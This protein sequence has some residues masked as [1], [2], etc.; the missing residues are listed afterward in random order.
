MK[1]RQL[2]ILNAIK[3]EGTITGAANRLFISQP[4]LSLAVKELET[5]LGVTLFIRNNQ[6]IEFT[7]FGDEAY[8]YSK[9]ILQYIDEIR[10]IPPDI[11]S[12]QAKILILSS[13]Y[14]HGFT[15][16]TDTISALEQEATGIC[17]Y[18]FA[19]DAEKI[20]WRLL[21]SN[22]LNEDVDLAVVKIY[23]FDFKNKMEQIKNENLVFEK[24]F[25]E[26]LVIVGRKDHPLAKKKNSISSLQNYQYISE[27]LKNNLNFYIELKYGEEFCLSSM[28]HFE[29]KYGII[30][31]IHNT[32]AF[33]VFSLE[34][35]ENAYKVYGIELEVIE[36]DDFDLRRIV[37]CLR[38]NRELNWAESQ[39]T[40]K[41]IELKKK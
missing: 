1:L 6:G 30:K 12:S 28:T 9:Q 20:A 13:N 39:F 22:L 41:L 38:K 5:E 34:E 15:L 2:E 31:Y 26:S 29:S 25:V 18:Q 24:L 32:D 3:E 19:N 36:I 11:D 33:S 40:E 27:D 4:S 35:V 8:I 16:L 7:S 14:Y 17:K 37:G 21:I 10:S 23:N